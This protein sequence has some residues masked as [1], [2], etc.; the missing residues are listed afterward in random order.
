M[1][2]ARYVPGRLELTSLEA[3]AYGGSVG[4]RITALVQEQATFDLEMAGRKLDSGELLRMI[5]LPL[6]FFGH[7]YEEIT[8]RG[9]LEADLCFMFDAKPIHPGLIRA[10]VGRPADRG[11]ITVALDLLTSRNAG[12]YHQ[13][14]A[15]TSGL[16]D[17]PA[18]AQS[19]RE[20][21]STSRGRSPPAHHRAAQKRTPA[22]AR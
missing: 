9:L 15:V 21:S 10:F 18:P 12:A 22:S 14:R 19:W 7:R 11:P 20:F 3:Q 13:D 16:L 5:D 2:H 17:L 8:R 6:P 4:G 1:A